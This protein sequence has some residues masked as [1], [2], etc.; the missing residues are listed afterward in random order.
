[1]ITSAND[2]EDCVIDLYPNRSVAEEVAQLD[3]GESLE[4]YFARRYNW[5]VL[6]RMA[7]DPD[8]IA[9]YSPP[10]RV[11]VYPG[12]YSGGYGGDGGGFG[13]AI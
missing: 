5:S 4:L 9:R 1:M 2:G 10:I 6:S 8:L 13:S 7:S 3:P 12:M 11:P